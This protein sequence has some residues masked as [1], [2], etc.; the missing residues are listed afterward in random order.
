MPAALSVLRTVH[1]NGDQTLEHQADEGPFVITDV[2]RIRFAGQNLT[3]HPPSLQ[4]A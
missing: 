3:F 1:D 4:S 2:R